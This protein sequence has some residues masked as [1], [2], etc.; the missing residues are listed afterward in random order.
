MAN[1]ILKKQHQIRVTVN[2]ATNE[3]VRLIEEYYGDNVGKVLYPDMVDLIKD[4][5]AKVP[6]TFK[7]NRGK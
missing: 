1:Q 5:A 3:D 2:D 6:E 4:R 7:I